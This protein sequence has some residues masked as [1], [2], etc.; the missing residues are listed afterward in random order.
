M[1]RYAYLSTTNNEMH[2][3]AIVG[4]LPVQKAYPSY[5][6]KLYASVPTKVLKRQRVHTVLMNA[7]RDACAIQ[8]TIPQ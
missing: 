8:L 6:I 1:L 7:H 5:I 4:K 3:T 2:L